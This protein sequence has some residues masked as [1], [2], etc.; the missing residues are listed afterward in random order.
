M[1]KTRFPIPIEKSY[2]RDIQKGVTLIE[3]VTLLM[4]ENEIKPTFD[5][6]IHDALMGDDVI[7]WIESLMVKLKQL[8]IGSFTDGDAKDMV[9]RYMRAIDSSNRN[10]VTSQVVAH[11]KSATLTATATV[12]ENQPVELAVNPLAG[13]AQLQDYIKGK[14]TENVS[15]I[16]GIRDDYATKVEQAI[17]RGVTEGQS[18]SEI[19]KTIQHQA[20]MSRDRASFIAR[21]QSG[22]IYGQLTKRRHQAAG[23]NNFQWETME[24]ERVRPGHAARQGAIYSYET[25]DL[26]PG[27]DF[28]CRCTADPIFDDEETDD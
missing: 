1:P 23:I 16:K 7:D 15:Y 3:S 4:L 5:R 6:G 24:D 13:E 22:S 14:I 27:E 21:D 20:H 12:P 28:N 9:T 11:S 19:G 10:N 18:Y 17:Y 25:A 8:I 2:A 26:L